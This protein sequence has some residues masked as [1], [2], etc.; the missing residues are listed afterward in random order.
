MTRSSVGPRPFTTRTFFSGQQEVGPRPPLTLTALKVLLGLGALGCYPHSQAYRGAFS[1]KIVDGAGR[2]ISGATVV[3]CT[4]DGPESFDGCPHRAEAWSDLEGR[5]QFS[6]L[7]EKVWSIGES[8]LPPTHL[9]ACARD[10]MGRLLEASIKVDASGATEPRI[11]V[12][13]SDRPVPQAAC[14]AP[15]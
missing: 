9:T 14:A 1:G 7:K 3:V 13:P 15:R 4:S 11:L 6:P 8:P 5:F 10:G 2:P 12:E